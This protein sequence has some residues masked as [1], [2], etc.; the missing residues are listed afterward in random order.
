MCLISS[1]E[2]QKRIIFKVHAP[3]HG[4]FFV[5]FK[6][7]RLLPGLSAAHS[8]R[9]SAGQAHRH[10]SASV[11][12]RPY[13]LSVPNGKHKLPPVCAPNPILE[14]PVPPSARTG[15]SPALSFIRPERQTQT[16][17]M[18]KQHF[19]Y[20]FVPSPANGTTPFLPATPN[21][22]SKGSLL[23]SFSLPPLSALFSRRFTINTCRLTSAASTVS[24]LKCPFQKLRRPYGQPAY[25]HPPADADVQT[26]KKRRY[27]QP[28]HS[29]FIHL[30]AC[31]PI[32]PFSS[33]TRTTFT[34]PLPG[35]FGTKC[36]S[37]FLLRTRQLPSILLTI[38]KVSVGVRQMP[39]T[40]FCFLPLKSVLM[41]R[42]EKL[43]IS[44]FLIRNSKVLDT[45]AFVMVNV[46]VAILKN[47]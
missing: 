37:P 28:P 31:Q 24:N 27:D 7:L 21:I 11:F 32:F 34:S 18:H 1:S 40:L 5:I 23:L 13:L 14:P 4:L 15:L 25:L 45:L 30:S 10:P 39:F 12:R 20:S 44:P 3:R 2:I 17:P 26:I 38:S 47:F 8:R 35:F 42:F 9:S 36:R 33:N 29:F 46:F 19:L 16:S 43:S 22:L 6:H 41:L